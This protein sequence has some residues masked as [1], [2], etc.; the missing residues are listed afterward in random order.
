MPS[1]ILEAEGIFA[2]IELVGRAWCIDVVYADETQGLEHDL[3]DLGK[4]ECAMVREALCHEYMA[5]E[6]GKAGD[7]A[8]ADRAKRMRVDIEEFAVCDI[9]D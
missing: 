9:G 5:I 8:Y 4:A 3:A 2:W 7:C 1:A 6:S